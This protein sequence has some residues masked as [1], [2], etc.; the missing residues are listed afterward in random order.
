VQRRPVPRAATA[1]PQLVVVAGAVPGAARK[2]AGLEV[3]APL[4]SSP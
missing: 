2:P 3:W 4:G 1:G